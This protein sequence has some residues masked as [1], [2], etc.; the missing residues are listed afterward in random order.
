MVIFLISLYFL[1]LLS[2]F[3]YV[4]KIKKDID[5]KIFILEKSIEHVKSSIDL[6][7]GKSLL[8]S[9]LEIEKYE[10]QILLLK[11]FKKYFK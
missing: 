9:C 2:C 6:S 10:S 8:I 3:L 4:K 11:S 7:K 5:N 1:T